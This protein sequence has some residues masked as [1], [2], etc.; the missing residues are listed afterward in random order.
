MRFIQF[1]KEKEVYIIDYSGFI[2]LEEGLLRMEELEK[3][4]SLYYSNRDTLKLLFDVRNTIWQSIET[5]NTLAKIARQKF[6]KEQN[7]KRMYT[8][9]LNNHYN[10]PS[11]ENENW[12][13]NKEEALEWLAQKR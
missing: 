12:F 9:I 4:F 1:L 13:T 7:N 11:F 8:A 5:H 2:D 10:I 6:T 3:Y